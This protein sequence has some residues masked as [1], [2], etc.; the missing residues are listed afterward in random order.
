MVRAWPVML[1]ACWKR[2]DRKEQNTPPGHMV[3]REVFCYEEL[4]DHLPLR[5]PGTMRGV[6]AAAFGSGVQ[7]AADAP[8]DGAA[9]LRL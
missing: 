3:F 1:S 5:D 7:F 6:A 2:I 8:S 9:G 4:Y